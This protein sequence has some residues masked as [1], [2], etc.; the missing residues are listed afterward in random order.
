MKDVLN[1]MPNPPQ[2]FGFNAG[3]NKFK[4]FDYKEAHSKSDVKLSS[5]ELK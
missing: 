2:Y 3:V 5:T 4:P 1:E